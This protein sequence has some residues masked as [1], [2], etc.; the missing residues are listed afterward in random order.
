MT[1]ALYSIENN[2]DGLKLYSLYNICNS[3]NNMFRY[4]VSAQTAHS[5]NFSSLGL[6]NIDDVKVFFSDLRKYKLYTL[7]GLKDFVRAMSLW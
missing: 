2:V 5:V 3:H 4:R 6:E 7:Q 1:R